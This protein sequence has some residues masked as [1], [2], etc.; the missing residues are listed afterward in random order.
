MGSLA[1]TGSAAA[2][3]GEWVARF[4]RGDRHA[5]RPD[6]EAFRPCFPSVPRP[7]SGIAE[8][9]SI[10]CASRAPTFAFCALALLVASAAVSDS[11]TL[12]VPPDSPRWELQGNAKAAEYQGRKCLLLDGGAAILNDLEMRDGVIDVDVATPASRGFFGIQFRIADDGANAEWVYLR[13]HKSGLP[14]ALQYTPV[15][16]T[17]LNWQIYNGPGFT[18]AVDIPKDAWFHVRLEVA[19]AQAKLY[20]KDL[21]KPALVMND[22]KSGKQKGQVALA[23]SDRRDL[24]LELRDPDDARGSL[25]AAPAADA[26]GNADEV[27][28]VA[29]LRRARAKSRAP[30]LAVRDARPSPGR[31]WRRSRPASSSSIGTARPRTRRSRSRRTFPSGWTLSRG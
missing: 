3:F 24:L 17:G 15:F 23:R 16:N 7:R 8:G 31:T 27:E 18:G 22:L 28:P 10:T 13:Q 1:I 14:D 11:Q 21:E 12:S 19:G 6:Q 26:A 29:V 30:A 2:G 5:L 20:V 25:G 4:G 9:S